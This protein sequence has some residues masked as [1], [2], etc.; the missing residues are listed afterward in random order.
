MPSFKR[1]QPRVNPAIPPPIIP[2]FLESS[3][4][5]FYPFTFLGTSIIAITFPFKFF[6]IS[7]ILLLDLKHALS[8]IVLCIY[9]Y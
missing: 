6:I 5:P 7:F 2:I 9:Y 3:V 4:I 1:V 8:C